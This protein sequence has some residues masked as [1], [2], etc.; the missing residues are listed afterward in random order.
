MSLFPL[1]LSWRRGALLAAALLLGQHAVAQDSCPPPLA[2]PSQA[3]LAQVM[4]DAKNRGFLW[5]FEKDGQVSYLYGTM[6]AQKLAWAGLGPQTRG[7]LK[8][9]HAVA[10][11]MDPLDPNAAAELKAAQVDTHSAPTDAA[12]PE[13]TLARLRARATAECA[14]PSLLQDFPPEMQLALVSLLAARRDG[15]EVTYGSEVMLSASARALQKP[16]YSLET[17][18]E[19]M[20]AL[21]APD[22]DER[23]ALLDRSLT[24][25]ADG[26]ARRALIQAAQHW[27]NSDG[28]ALSRYSDWCECADTESERAQ[29]KRLLDERNPRLADRVARLQAEQGPL[30]VGIGALHMFGPG[31]LPDQLR[32][33]G[34][35]VTR[36]Y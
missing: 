11:E 21:T 30:F 12:L 34:Y 13:T 26:S 20:H 25:L 4:R 36:V 28:E 3:V 7:A 15:L 2:P 29:L 6:H 35:T 14:D 31:N 18:A 1:T 5:K 16:V 32:Q 23:N 17:A 8:A 27:A 19:Q 24:A 22:A 33:R 9:T 10:L